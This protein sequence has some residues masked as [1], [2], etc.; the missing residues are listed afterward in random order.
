[1][2]GADGELYAAMIGEQP[3]EI[4]YFTTDESYRD[5]VPYTI[6]SW[7]NGLSGYREVYI[8]GD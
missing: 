8:V 6:D 7:V 2:K 4:L 3:E 1:M 5:Y